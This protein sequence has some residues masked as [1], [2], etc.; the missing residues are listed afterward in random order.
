VPDND[1]LLDPQQLA[2]LLKPG[3]MVLLGQPN[4]PTG[5]TFAAAALRDLAASHPASLFVVDESFIGFTDASQ[6]LQQ[7]RPANL[8]VVLLTS[9]TPFRAAAGLPGTLLKSISKAARLSAY[10][11][12]QLPGPGSGARAVQ[13]SGLLRSTRSMVTQQR[14][15]LDR[16]W[17]AARPD[18]LPRRGQLP[19]FAV[20]SLTLDAPLL[21]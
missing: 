9:C 11:V 21:C 19:A 6:S 16:C 17:A 14:Q 10:L 15:Q 1:F 12:G 3:Q 4:N 13:G 20:G 2:P 8:L 5:R 18:D 7:D